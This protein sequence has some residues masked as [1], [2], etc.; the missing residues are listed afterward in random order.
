VHDDPHFGEHQTYYL[1]AMAVH[2]S[3]QNATEIEHHLFDLLR[4]RVIA[5]RYLWFSTLVEDRFIQT[6]P[7]WLRAAEVL[8]VVDNYLRSGQRF[9]YLHTALS[10]GDQ[11]K[12]G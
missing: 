4:T 1:L 8:R 11:P 5:Q 12:M 2:P 9:I 10:R 3:V 6:G 7:P